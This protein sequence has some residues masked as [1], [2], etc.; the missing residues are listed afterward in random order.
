MSIDLQHFDQT[1]APS[2]TT[3]AGTTIAQDLF[4]QQH[5]A[6]DPQG[7]QNSIN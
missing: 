7:R 5:C 1:F 4:L 2:P 3:G 6:D